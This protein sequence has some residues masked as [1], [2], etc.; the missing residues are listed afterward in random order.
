MR[1]DIPCDRAGSEREDGSDRRGAQDSRNRS[2][3]GLE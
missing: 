2:A 1:R 3:Q